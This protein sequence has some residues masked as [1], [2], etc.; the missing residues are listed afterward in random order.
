M[1]TR[2]RPGSFQLRTLKLDPDLIPTVQGLGR[3][4]FVATDHKSSNVLSEPIESSPIENELPAYRAISSRAVLSVLCG[5]L[6]VFSI[7]SPFFYIFA[8]LAVVLG[9][10]ADWNIQRYPDILTGRGLAQTGAALGLIF[11]LGIFTVSSVQG[12]IRTRNAGSFAKYYAEVFKTGT[13]AD[14][15]WLEYPPVVRKS[16]SAEDVMKKAQ[17]KKEAMMYEM[18]HGPLRNLKKRLD[19]SKDQEIHFVRLENEARDGL[20]LVALALFEVHGPESKDFPQKEEYAL[21]TLKGTSEDGKGYEWWVDDFQYPYK[22]ATAT[23]P[24]KPVD[25]GHGHAH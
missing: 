4:R 11:G 8:V 25:D 3:I 6:A 23:L 24:E 20:T 19:S 12:F 5:I 17:S 16:V 10:T 13:L 1:A 7:A 22:P 9:F 2:A 14:L 15:L 18:K 21:A